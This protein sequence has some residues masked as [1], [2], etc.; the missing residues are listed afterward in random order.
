MLLLNPDTEVLPG[1]LEA[2]VGFMDRNPQCGIC[3]PTLEDA[4]GESAGDVWATFFWRYLA[5]M[6]SLDRIIQ[7]RRRPEC[8]DVISGACLAFRHELV[9]KIGLLDENLFWCEDVDF[10]VRARQAGYQVCVVPGSRV[11]H[12]EGQSGKSNPGLMLEKQYTSKIAFLHKHASS[13]QV[14]LTTGLFLAEGAARSI[15]WKVLFSVHGL[16][17]AGIRGARAK[18][19]SGQDVS[20][21]SVRVNFLSLALHP[22]LHQRHT[23]LHPQA[24][25]SEHLRTPLLMLMPI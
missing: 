22:R 20:S 25:G 12:L 3:G 8:A 24:L 23:S 1:A 14:R 21:A 9:A 18:E 13:L 6:L 17:E 7:W 15:K 2:I 4:G 5:A 11:M 19:R 10:C 16:S